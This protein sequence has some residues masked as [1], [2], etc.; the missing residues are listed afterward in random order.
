MLLVFL[1]VGDVDYLTDMFFFNDRMQ[2]K[3]WHA[4]YKTGGIEKKNAIIW[5]KHTAL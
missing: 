1:C 5:K 4:M 3:M 2:K